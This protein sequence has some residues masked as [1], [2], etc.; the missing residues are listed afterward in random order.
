MGWIDDVVKAARG[1]DGPVVVVT[2][3]DGEEV[4]VALG[5]GRKRWAMLRRALV[6]L[7]PQAGSWTV[8]SRP[9]GQTEL[10]FVGGGWAVDA[11]ETAAPVAPAPG[12]APP[13][14]SATVGG[15]PQ[16][17]LRALGDLLLKA[18]AEQAASFERLLAPIMSAWQSLSEAV[19]STG[20][21][22]QARAD[23][24]AEELA[25]RAAAATP[26]SPEAA[27]WG[28]LRDLLGE[29]RGKGSGAA[30]EVRR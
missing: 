13:G 9:D 21:L 17:E 6:S 23:V 16:S 1:A 15:V 8:Y 5:S 30:G 27:K 10:A 19:M 4:P 18:Q 11:E 25:A 28:A 22:A 3:G 12:C 2:R 7:A 20:L 26:D 24:L 14:P 29:V